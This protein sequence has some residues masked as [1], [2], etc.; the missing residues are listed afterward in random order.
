[1]LLA[2]EI[3]VEKPDK[4]FGSGSGIVITM[5][6]STGCIF[7]GTA[8]GAKGKH[9][10]LVGRKAADFLVENHKHGGCVDEY[11]QDQ[12]IVFMALA[13][14]RSQVLSGPISLHTETAIHFAERLTPAK[15]TVAKYNEADPADH[16]MLITCDG[17][18]YKSSS[19][20]ASTS[21]TSATKRALPDDIGGDATVVADESSSSSSAR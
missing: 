16:R 19:A 17:M 4:A 13:Q 15:F 8:C 21:S 6:T 2:P 14:G 3:V 5:T 7:A 20:S 9:A 11:L 10:E 1:M 12:L 18:A